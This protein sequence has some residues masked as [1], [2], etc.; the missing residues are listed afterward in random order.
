MSLLAPWS[1]LLSD[2]AH[3]KHPENGEVSPG[4]PRGETEEEEGVGE[5]GGSSPQRLQMGNKTEQT[6]EPH[7]GFQMPAAARHKPCLGAPPGYRRC[8]LDDRYSQ[9]GQVY[10]LRVGT[11]VPEVEVSALVLLAPAVSHVHISTFGVWRDRTTQVGS[12][13]AG[14]GDPP[15]WESTVSADGQVEILKSICSKC[16]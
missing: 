12:Q 4:A 3:H 11:G 1:I 16:E 14:L 5:Q 10:A 7:K 15:E 6:Q 2:L 9:Q 13:S 8:H